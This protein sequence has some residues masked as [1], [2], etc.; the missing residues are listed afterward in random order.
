M[1]I[2]LPAWLLR[3]VE[4]SWNTMINNWISA[5]KYYFVDKE[6]HTFVASKQDV[7]VNAFIFNTLIHCRI[8]LSGEADSFMKFQ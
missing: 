8:D 6:D 5:K 1:E 7:K 3:E 2:Y 4:V